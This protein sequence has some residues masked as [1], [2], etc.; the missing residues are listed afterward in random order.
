M[1]FI[2]SLLVV[3]FVL[4]MGCSMA[5]PQ[6]ALSGKEEVLLY[7]GGSIVA[8]APLNELNGETR[9]AI[10]QLLELM[11]QRS[12]SP[13][14]ATYVPRLLVRSETWSLNC[15]EQEVIINASNWGE[16][17]DWKQG[18]LQLQEEERVLL[19]KILAG[20]HQQERVR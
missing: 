5:P 11:R 13:S 15:R 14:L 20:I 19:K 17:G 16:A 2:R 7:E 10:E 18:V 12:A 6:L 9:E 3:P 4:L 1:R 8:Q